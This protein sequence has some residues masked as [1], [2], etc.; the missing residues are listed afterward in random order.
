ML[1]I[2]IT[3]VL[4]ITIQI[5]IEIDPLKDKTAREV[6][7]TLKRQFSRHG[8]PNT[9][10]SDNGPPFNSNEFQQFATNYDMEHVTSSPH[11]PQ[12]DRKVENAIKT[13][14]SL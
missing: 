2:E 11:Y 10:M 6:I 3:S 9:L 8:I 1:I 13:A 7:H 14:K 4:W 5:E 12:S